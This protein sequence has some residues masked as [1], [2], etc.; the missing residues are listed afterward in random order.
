M[1]I[2]AKFNLFSQSNQE[3][4]TEYHLTP[5]K[6][7][8]WHIKSENSKNGHFNDYSELSSI[9]FFFFYLYVHTMFGS[10]LSPS[11]PE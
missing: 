2:N 11:L 9:L 1:H 10:F 6:N 5:S 7:I 4:V 3:V 8:I